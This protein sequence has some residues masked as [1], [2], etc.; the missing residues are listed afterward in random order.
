MSKSTKIKELIQKSKEVAQEIQQ[1]FNEAVEEYRLAKEK[2]ELLLQELEVGVL[3]RAK[4]AVKSI[5]G[6]PKQLSEDKESQKP[7][8]PDFEFE[9]EYTIVEPKKGNAGAVI[10]GIVTS[11]V[12]FVGFG[13]GGAILKGL[14][15]SPD[16]LGRTFFEEA[17]SFY[18]SL[19]VGS[20]HAA[21]ALGIA[22]SAAISI[23]IGYVVYLLLKQK[24]VSQNLKK[25]Q[26]IYDSAMAYTQNK[27]EEIEKISALMQFLKEASFHCEGAKWFLEEYT[28]K[29]NRIRF[30]EGND[31]TSFCDIS[32]EDVNTLL[33]LMEKVDTTIH[34]NIIDHE[35]ILPEARKRYEDLG[36]YVL[37]IK[38]RI[39]HA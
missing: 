9:S 7:Q 17:Y 23:L 25:A 14:N 5:N 33:E 10:W 29:T 28:A 2:F 20:S 11:I 21:P 4:K 30:F 31:F 12:I 32:K 18:S 1:N 38:E 34:R 27:Q 26:L 8:L 39:Y 6:I 35:D 36:N 24:A 13:L 3:E 19:I 16:L 22:V 15:L 37:S